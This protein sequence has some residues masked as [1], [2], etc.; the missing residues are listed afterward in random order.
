MDFPLLIRQRLEELG[1]EQ[2]N[3][4][5]AAQVTESYISQLLD[6]KEGAPGARADRHLRQDGDLLEAPCRE[7][8]HAGRSQPHGRPE[9]SWRTPSPLFKEM[10]EL[11][12]RKYFRKRAAHPCDVREG[13]S[14]PS[15]A[16]SPRS[17]WTLPS[18]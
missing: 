4:A 16:S 3:L 7:V 12:L 6:R 14:A 18:D 5:A 10:R 1:T 9:E 15:N 2:R 8:G 13:P 17:C 11:I